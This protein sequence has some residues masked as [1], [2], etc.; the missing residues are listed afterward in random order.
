MS[1]MISGLYDALRSAGAPEVAAYD[2]QIAEIKGD[3]KMLKAMLGVVI[4]LCISIL[5][6]VIKIYMGA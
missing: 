3:V 2:N 5:F 6:F 1:L 4:A